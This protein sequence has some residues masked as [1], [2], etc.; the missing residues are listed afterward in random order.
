MVKNSSGYILTELQFADLVGW[1]SSTTACSLSE[2]YREDVEG[3]APQ[4]FNSRTDGKS[5]QPRDAGGSRTDFLVLAG[6]QC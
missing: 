4:I 2:I 3:E 1:W 6:E 5:S